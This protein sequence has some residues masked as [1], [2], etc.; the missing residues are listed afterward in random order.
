[1]K[2]NDAVIGVFFV[3]FA[4]A[5]ITYA[6]LTFPPLHGQN[7][8]SRDFP[9]LIGIGFIICGV[10]LIFSGLKSRAAGSFVG[11]AFLSL[12]DWISN[13]RTALNFVSV[14]LGVLLFMM[15]VN[16]TGFALTSFAL[17]L[18]LFHRFGNSFAI[19]LVSSVVTTGIVYVLFGTL[20]R[21]P[22]PVGVLGL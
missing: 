10:L 15:L 6:Q 1:M 7:F 14:V 17:L 16:F 2:F 3:V 11:A 4:I 22:L 9:T 13:N 20:L 12:G 19:S 5:E 8:D 21:V 18:V